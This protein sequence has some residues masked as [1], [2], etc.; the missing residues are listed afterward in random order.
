M[1]ETKMGYAIFRQAK[2]WPM[3]LTKFPSVAF[4]GGGKLMGGEATLFCIVVN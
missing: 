1:K 2:A 3:V 4:L